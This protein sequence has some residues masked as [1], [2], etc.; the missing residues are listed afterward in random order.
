MLTINT[1]AHRT[2]LHTWIILVVVKQYLVHT[3]RT[4]GSTK[5]LSHTLSAIKSS[6]RRGPSAGHPPP[7]TRPDTGKTRK[8]K[9]HAARPGGVQVRKCADQA[10]SIFHNYEMW[11]YF[12]PTP[13][14][15]H[16]LTPPH[17]IF[18]ISPRFGINQISISRGQ[19][20]A[21]FRNNQTSMSPDPDRLRF[22]Q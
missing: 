2:L 20:I 15:I 12:D 3:G 6:F 21:T 1:R 22:Y 7:H 18:K 10:I 17:G 5:C 8:E 4:D 9:F 14:R 13:L 16:I 11:R 19:N